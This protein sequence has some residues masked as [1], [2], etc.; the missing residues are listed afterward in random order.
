MSRVTILGVPVDPVTRE[1]AL[2]RIMMMLDKN[3]QHHVMTPNNEMLVIAHKRHI[4]RELLNRTHLNLA[5]S[6]GLL[7]AA[8]RTGQH[9]PERVTGVDTMTELCKRLDASHPV[10]FLGAG[11]GV[12]ENAAKILQ[13]SNPQLKIAGSFAG[14]PSAQDAPA[15]IAMINTAKPH[16]LLVAYGAPQQ[17][18]WIGRYLKDL[19]S[20]R[21]AMGIGGSFD[22]ITGL[23]KRAPVFIQ[24]SGLE[25]LWR[26]VQEPSRW[27]RMWNAVVV[28]P[29]LVVSGK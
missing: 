23:R 18:F 13:R 3:E 4:F 26:F 9:L 6:T 14:T 27:K 5:D 2:T 7:W 21:V 24:K 22:F 19:P 29:L 17:D 25:W 11:D 10:F 28:F 8:R 15:I 16:L 1:E 20:V 12:A